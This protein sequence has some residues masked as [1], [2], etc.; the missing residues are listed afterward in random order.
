MMDKEIKKRHLKQLAEYR[1]SILK[2]PPLRNLFLELTTRC[3]S[4]CIHCGSRCGE[5]TELFELSSDQ[6][7]KILEDVR[8]DFDISKIKL[9]I[10]GGEPLLRKDFF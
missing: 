4:K 6:Y 9:D 10:T 1:N 5:G 3:N 8:R 2:N 7:K